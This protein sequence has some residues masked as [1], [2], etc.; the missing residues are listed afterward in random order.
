VAKVIV[1][2]EAI[3]DHVGLMN[4][5]N[6]VAVQVRPVGHHAMAVDWYKP[7]SL[8]DML[9][10]KRFGIVQLFW[11]LTPLRKPDAILLDI[12]KNAA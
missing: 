7:G 8:L 9:C 4:R 12:E 11:P 1:Q 3:V 6:G 5:K 2:I 10:Y